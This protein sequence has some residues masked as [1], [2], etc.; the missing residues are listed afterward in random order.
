MAVIVAMVEVVVLVDEEDMAP[1]GVER[2]ATEVSMGV[3]PQVVVSLA[4]LSEAVVTVVVML[5][6]CSAEG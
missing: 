5:V 2:M 3:V 4:V 1:M 6:A